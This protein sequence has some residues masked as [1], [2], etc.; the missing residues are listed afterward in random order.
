MRCMSA[1]KADLGAVFAITKF[2][3]MRMI[4]GAASGSHTK[5]GDFHRVLRAFI[6]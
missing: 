3:Q 4:L 6:T 5:V 1:W 2:M